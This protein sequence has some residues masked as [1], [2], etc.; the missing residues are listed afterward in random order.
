ME[1]VVRLLLDVHGRD[2][3]SGTGPHELFLSHNRLL[4]SPLWGD[5]G[6]WI[7]YDLSLILSRR[8]G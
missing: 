8:F 2:A 5:S 4:A 6:P 7:T 3:A 1:G